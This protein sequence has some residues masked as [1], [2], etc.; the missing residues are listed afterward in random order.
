MS[1]V[2]MR[3]E[4]DERHNIRDPFT[5]DPLTQ[6]IS[7]TAIAGWTNTLVKTRVPQLFLTEKGLPGHV[8]QLQCELNRLKVCKLEGFSSEGFE[9]VMCSIKFVKKAAQK[10]K[11][12]AQQRGF[13]MPNNLVLEF[14]FISDCLKI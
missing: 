1:I 9:T 7:L 6:C 4:L 2:R 3:S 8:N 10:S 14:P 13:Q 12:A 11:E 5:I